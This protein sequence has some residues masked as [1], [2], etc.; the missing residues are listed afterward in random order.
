MGVLST[1]TEDNKPWGS[2]IYFTI[3]EDLNVFFV[4]RQETFKY[5]NLDK[6]PVAAL[7][8]ADEENQTTVQLMGHISK[9]PVKDYM[10]IVFTRLAEIQ[11]KDDINWA[12]PL[13]KVHKGDYIALQLTPSK[14]QYADFK[15]H[16][17]DIDHEYIEKII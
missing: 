6:S 8:I 15:K 9:V 16:T 13:E 3:D 12:P 17:T 7:T 5:Q 14:L 4:T 11:P 2:A 1:V 10:D